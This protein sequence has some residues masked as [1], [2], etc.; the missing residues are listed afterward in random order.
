[1]EKN[2]NEYDWKVIMVSSLICGLTVI[3]TIWGF[4]LFNF[5][6]YLFAIF[7]SAV[8]SVSAIVMMFISWLK[9]R[10]IRT[11][12]EEDEENDGIDH[13]FR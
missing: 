7:I 1:M 12:Y 3:A 4:F 2:M 9:M 10:D 5:I 13:S 6:P 8:F 11:F